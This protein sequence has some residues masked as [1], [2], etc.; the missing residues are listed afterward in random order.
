MIQKKHISIEDLVELLFG[1]T[2]ILPLGDR[3]F[4][5][6][7][8]IEIAQEIHAVDAHGVETLVGEFAGEAAIAV[9]VLVT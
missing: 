6:R 7:H 5:F 8:A 9:I 2:L 4:D 3:G 1:E